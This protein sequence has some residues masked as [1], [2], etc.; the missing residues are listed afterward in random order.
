MP[1]FPMYQVDA[2]ADRLFEGNPA[3]VCV[4]EDWLPDAIMQAIAGENNLA[5]TAFLVPEGDRWLIRWFTPTV[6]VDLCGHAT[7]ASGHALMESGL[8]KDR[9]NFLSP[10]SGPLSVEKRGERI[11]LNFPCDEV[12]E[13]T[14]PE[15]LTEAIGVSSMAVFQGKTDLLVLVDSEE[16]LA[17][18]KPNM[19]VIS[20]LAARGVIVSAPGRSHD[21]VSRFFAPQAG[22]P[23]DPVTGSAHTTL[24]PVW[25]ERLGKKDLQARQISP[26]GGNLHC[27]WLD[28]GRVEI[29]GKAITFFQTTISLPD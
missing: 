25:S 9:V 10:R 4:L 18:I 19:E 1:T 6:E 15:E 2:F 3:G 7:L 24:T 12:H 16:T 22:V 17:N 23:E 29:G 13:T 5:E 28:N 27:K 26:R 8:G 14:P 20:R 11:Y 21:F